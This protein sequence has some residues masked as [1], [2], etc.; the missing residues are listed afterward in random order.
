MIFHSFDVTV[1][2][3]EEQ[4]FNCAFNDG[5]AF[6]VDFGTTPTQSDYNGPYEVTPTE[7][8][9]ILPTSDKVLAANIVVNPIPNNYG[10]ITWNGSTITVS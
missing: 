9:Q 1:N 5:G 10:L 7:N 6:N 3:N 8:T 2:F 4:S